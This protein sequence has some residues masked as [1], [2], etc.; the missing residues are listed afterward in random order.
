[1]NQP[2]RV[3]TPPKDAKRPYTQRQLLDAIRAIMCKGER[4]IVPNVQ[5]G[6]RKVTG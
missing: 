4:V 5:A 3:V 6:K 1:M 2:P